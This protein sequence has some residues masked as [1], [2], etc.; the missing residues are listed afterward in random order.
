MGDY[1]E[2]IPSLTSIADLL[3]Q[4][5]YMVEIKEMRDYTFVILEK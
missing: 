5:Y 2:D 1:Y 3:E 4:G